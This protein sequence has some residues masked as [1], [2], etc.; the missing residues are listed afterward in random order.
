[1]RLRPRQ[2]TPFVTVVTFLTLGVALLAPACGGDD[3][4][5]AGS[6]GM[7]SEGDGDGDV[8]SAGGASPADTGGVMDTLRGMLDLLDDEEPEV[9]GGEPVS[10]EPVE[11][12]EERCEIGTRACSCTE[13]HTC[14]EGLDCQGGVCG[15][16]SRW[17][18]WS[19]GVGWPEAQGLVWTGGGMGGA[20]ADNGVWE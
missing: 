9:D 14:N 11:K 13:N 12:P 2:R 5:D 7:T 17:G 3:K 18:P 10:A 20:P 15:R 19:E 4:G 1:M 8:D 6:G 16:A